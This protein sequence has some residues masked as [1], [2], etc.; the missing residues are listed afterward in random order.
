MD[1]ELQN[2]CDVVFFFEGETVAIKN[3]LSQIWLHVSDNA[4]DASLFPGIENRNSVQWVDRAIKSID[5]LS[6]NLIFCH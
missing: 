5:A 1:F 4:I 3:S 2:Q 6:A